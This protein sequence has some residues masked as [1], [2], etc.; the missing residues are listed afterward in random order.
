MED[1]QRGD[2]RF[3][4]AGRS[5]GMPEHRLDRRHRQ[6]LRPIAEHEAD[7]ARFGAIVVRRGRPVRVHV[8]DS[9]GVDRRVRQR[10]AHGHRDGPAVGLGRGRMKSLAGQA[11]AGDFGVDP[12]APAP[13]R[14][15]ILEQQ[16][17]GAFTDIH[18]GPTTI[19]RTAAAGVHDAQRI[20]P[21]EGQSRENIAAAGQR[22]V[23]LTQPDRVGRLADGH[24]A[25]GT[26]GDDARAQSFEAEMRGDHV[27]GRAVEMIPD[28]R[29]SRAVQTA[30]EDRLDVA[31]GPDE[32]GRSRAEDHA[33]AR[34]VEGTQHDARII[35]RFLSGDDTELIAARPAPAL[36]WRESRQKAIV[37]D[38]T[39][40]LAAIA[41]L[42]EQRQRPNAA[43]AFDRDWPTSRR[44]IVPMAVTSPI[45]V[46]ATLALI[47][48]VPRAARLARGRARPR[49]SRRRRPRSAARGVCPRAAP[50]REETEM[51]ATRRCTRRTRPDASPR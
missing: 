41:F 27:D 33:D 34:R 1:G 21:A 31:L 2:R 37:I 26:R 4:A 38:F 32:I 42:V 8:L 45:P 23:N 10:P 47:A 28:V 43:L 13:G 20:E 22:R 3:E 9:I 40:N 49:A 35:E 48:R 15:E 19:E 36:Q 11:M 46:M 14:I 50:A 5:Q 39:G 7:A 6:P 18:A 12:G 24:R 51:A 30:R 16:H 17:R 25:R 44:G 29:R